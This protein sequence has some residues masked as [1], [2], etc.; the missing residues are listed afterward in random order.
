M[1]RSLVGAAGAVLAL[2]L[3]AAAA[4][5]APPQADVRFATF[6]AS[7]N[8]GSAGL[9]TAHLSRPDRRR[10]VPP[11]GEER[12]GSGAADST[13]R[14]A[15]RRV[16]SVEQRCRESRPG[17]FLPR[18]LPRGLAERRAADRLPVRVHRAV[19][20]RGCERQGPRQ[21]RRGGH[22]AGALGYANDAFG[23]GVLPRPVRTGRVLAL[24][25]RLRLRSAPSSSSSGRTCPGT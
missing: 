16:R 21:Q 25:D 1:R 17:G 2:V 9:L 20:H 8:R 12:R 3:V 19:E 5:A 7:L 24:P 23:F 6:N 14:L 11:A 4:T 18:Q 13:R 10:P 15:R 22:D